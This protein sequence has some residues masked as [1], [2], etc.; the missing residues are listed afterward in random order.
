MMRLLQFS[1]SPYAAKV[2]T[3]LKLTK[4]PCEL[5]EVPYTD[6]KE[7]VALTGRLEVPV[8]VDGETV[9]SDSPRIVAWLA[10]KSGVPLTSPPLSV[11][12]EQWAD[13]PFEE[14]AFRLACPGLESFMRK[15]Q[16]A[17]AGALFRLIKERKYGAG[18]IQRWRDEEATWLAKTKATL[19][20]L[21]ETLSRSPYLLGEAPSVA[22]CAVVGQLHMVEVARPGFVRAEVPGLAEWFERLR[23]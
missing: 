19:A 17:E 7:L 20:P 11:V 1:Y 2:R 5:V 14:V 4:L 15:T 13:E 6:R 3:A 16:G 12:L 9:V 21:V 23:A 8:L 10:E 18:I 22:D